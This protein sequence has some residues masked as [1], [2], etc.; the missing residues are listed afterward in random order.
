MELKVESDGRMFPTTDK[1]TSVIDTLQASAKKA[2]VKV[3][4]R[5]KVTDVVRNHADEENGSFRICC[6]VSQCQ[7]PDNLKSDEALLK[8]LSKGEINCDRVI[9]APGSSRYSCFLY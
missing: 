1:S 7:L 8:Q 5:V 9:L 3:F 6:T 4:K 2:R